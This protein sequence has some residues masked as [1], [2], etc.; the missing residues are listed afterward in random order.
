M[1]FQERLLTELKAEAVRR[2]D[3]QRARR[4]RKAVTIRVAAAAAIAAACTLVAIVAPTFTGSRAAAY[5]L[6]RNA[7]G[8]ITVTIK[9]FRDPERLE[10]DLAEHG[11]RTDITYLPQHERC[12][13]DDRG[14]PV[15]PQPP[16]GTPMRSKAMDEWVAKYGYH[17]P[18]SRAIRMMSPEKS[19]NSFA[20]FPEHIKQGQTLVVQIGESHRTKQW[21]LGAFLIAGPVKPCVFEDDPY[22][23]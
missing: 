16:P 21:K 20:I 11:A 3:E 18:T 10:R 23:N 1:T 4:S 13:E 19:P 9:E 12:T 5:A 6:T 15:D 7:D 2:A 8:S 17:L 14:V 22:W